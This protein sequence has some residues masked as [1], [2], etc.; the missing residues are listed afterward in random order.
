MMQ[1]IGVANDTQFS[2][3]VIMPTFNNA[4]TL[5]DVYRRVAA[6]DLPII[7]VNDGSTDD[8]SAWL[9][10]SESEI[11]SQRL[12]VVT[13]P[14]NLGKAAA[15]QT[16]FA[17]ALQRGLTHAI[18]I[19]T[20]GQLDP[21]DIPSL[22]DQAKKNPR[23]LILGAR[24]I[25]KDDYPSRSR[26]G[27][28]LSNLAI[29]I[30]CGG[31][32]TDSQCGLRVYPLEMFR[33]VHCSTE[34]FGFEAAIITHAVW[35]GFPVIN[36]PVHCRYFPHEQRVSHF[37]PWRDS[38]HGVLLHSRLLVGKLRRMITAASGRATTSTSATRT[39]SNSS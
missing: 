16:G 33:R 22:L 29:R 10:A 30:E 12:S 6:L 3:V 27:R 4:A 21:E 9:A 17:T 24:D 23:A 39:I 34:R 8:T 15:M 2:P 31:I 14:N 25:A 37:R 1:P 18:T 28:R 19:D 32:V 20:D 38:L 7:I 11:N 13:H 5:P 36:V 35:H 26:I